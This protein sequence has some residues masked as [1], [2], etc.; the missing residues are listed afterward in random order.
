MK[1]PL[2]ARLESRFGEIPFKGIKLLTWQLFAIYCRS[3]RVFGNGAISDAV[4]I[5]WLVNVT[6][7]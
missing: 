3:K 7:V 1:G 2:G 4:F 5:P 6:E